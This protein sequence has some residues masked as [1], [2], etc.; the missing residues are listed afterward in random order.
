MGKKNLSP[1]VRRIILTNSSESNLEWAVE[2]VKD[3]V[4]LKF[5]KVKFELSDAHKKLQGPY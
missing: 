4:E 1:K 2:A 3:L 5:Y